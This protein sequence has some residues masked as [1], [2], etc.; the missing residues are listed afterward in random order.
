MAE[1]PGQRR[2][3]WAL[4]ILLAALPGG[5]SATQRVAL[6]IGNASYE[7][8]PALA[9]PLN[10]A[11]DIG[12]ALGRLGFSVTR[13]ENVDDAAMRRGLKEF[14]RAAAASE[15]A[16]VFYAG[17]GI[18]VDGRNF[19]V[20]VDARL[21]SDEDV[22]YEV[23][24]LELVSRAVE[25]ASGLRLVILD[26]CRDNPFAAKM[27]R[28]GATRSIG[29][30]LARVEPAEETLVAYAAKEGTVAADGVGRNSPY[31][32]ALLTYLEEPGLEVN[33]LFRKV[34]DAVVAATGG[35]QIP[36]TYGSLSSREVYLA[37]P[38]DP[39]DASESQPS[40]AEESD[41]PGTLAKQQAAEQEL[42]FWEMVKDSEDP[43]DIHVY[44]DRYPEGT[45]VALARNRLKRL[46]RAPRED[47]SGKVPDVA[48]LVIEPTATSAQGDA[49]REFWALVKES[50]V[51]SDFE[52]FLEYFPDGVYAPLA[53]MRLRQ[54]QRERSTSEVV[55]GDA[56]QASPAEP[57]PAA[58]TE[59][60]PAPETVEFSLGLERSERRR[61]QEALASL[62]F[63]PGPPDGLFGRR[64]RLA[65]RGYQ[66]AK[67]LEETG[68]LTGEQA[69]A[70]LGVGEEA[71]RRADDAAFAQAQS[72]GTVDAYRRYLI[73]YPNGLHVTEA[74]E[75][76]S[77]LRAKAERA[78]KEAE[79]RKRR[80]DDAA[81]ARAKSVGTAEAYRGYVRA[82]PGGLHVT[83]ARERESALRA[84]AE[85]AE[86]ERAKKEA[87]ARKRRADDA[88][89]ARAKSAG[90][91]E[92]YRGYVRAYPSGLHVAE[93]RERESALR[94]KAKRAEAERAKKEAEARKRRA[95]DAAFARAKS[96]GTVEAYRRYLLAYPSG[97]HV[98]EARERESA[99]R[100]KAK[101]TK[102]KRAEA[103]RAEAERAK[104]EAEARKRRADDAAFA[105]AK[106]VGTVD[107]Y[108]EYLDSFPAG[109][110]ATEARELQSALR[111][112][113]ASA[114]PEPGDR[115]RDCPQCPEMVVIPAGSY[116]LRNINGM[117]IFYQG[118]V[119]IAYQLAV[120]VNEVTFAEWD[121]C[122]VAGGCSHNPGDKGW[123]RDKRPVINVSWEDAQ[124]YVRWLS[125]ETGRAYRLLSEFEW[126]Y[127]AR[128]GTKTHYHWGNSLGRNRANCADCGSRWDEKQT[129]P[130]GTFPANAFGLRDAHGNVQEW[131][132]DC[133]SKHS[134]HTGEGPAE[135]PMNGSPRLS[136]HG[137][138]CNDRI[139]RGGS[140]DSTPRSIR[141]AKRMSLP[142]TQRRS[143]TGFR[144]ARTLD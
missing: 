3:A 93:A 58:S 28:S 25:R 132:E 27:Q 122:R 130:V 83:E 11:T 26:A 120:G 12:A 5:A 39:S 19:L 92:A 114:D 104:K 35:G 88:A 136:G 69:E 29:R 53:R 70:L 126:E 66:E 64:T 74:R 106:S 56:P 10:D 49:E 61:I 17:H 51:T 9:N 113:L 42:L 20:P 135:G 15:V 62:A 4:V 94:S 6:V 75:R 50:D 65:I 59:P 33:L 18:E 37:E 115:F 89:F 34:R 48:E 133:W 128:A 21:A 101:R 60:V 140:W 13:L 90:T 123:G 116:V 45:Y 1:F 41:T 127:A 76:E 23:V 8:A 52:V 105:Q 139:V 137:G 47:E 24:P 71:K 46:E 82:Y 142:L 131:V 121:A 124:A 103:K 72:S 97:L 40:I 87:E 112:K 32:E 57:V 67:G 22:E 95:D 129:S 144:V 143:D 79:A 119:R 38:P 109:R 91:V 99:L 117:E 16:L 118:R 138:N 43:A 107:S 110:H 77:A 2:W 100:T 54:L 44:L 73:A 98:A 85:R 78:K 125:R 134:Y 96:A 102:A 141:S 81:F 68:Y 80:A 63:D 14:R 84:K 7:H 31:S 55:A 108:A 36:F 86:A 111:A 30:G